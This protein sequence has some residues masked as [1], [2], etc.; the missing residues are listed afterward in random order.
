MSKG[1]KKVQK[2]VTVAFRRSLEDLKQEFEETLVERS[3]EVNHTLERIQQFVTELEELSDVSHVNKYI[4]E[5]RKLEGR[6]E[7]VSTLVTWV[8]QEESLFKFQ[9]S[10]FPLLAELKVMKKVFY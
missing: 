8:N 4:R 3:G 10:S 6:L 2:A 7:K 5:V 1:F 9:L